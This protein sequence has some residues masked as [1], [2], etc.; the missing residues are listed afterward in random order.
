MYALLRY[1]SEP[2][3]QALARSCGRAVSGTA[4][5]HQGAYSVAARQLSTSDD[6]VGSS[7]PAATASG[8]SRKFA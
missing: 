1:A 7:S 2:A 6:A 3:L 5:C 4:A 8:A